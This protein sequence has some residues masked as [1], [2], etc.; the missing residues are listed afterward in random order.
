MISSEMGP[1]VASTRA[2][3][4]TTPSSVSLTARSE[5]SS[6]VPMVACG[7]RERRTFTSVW[8]SARSFSRT[9]S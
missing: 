3:L 5:T 2:P 8:V 4:T 9:C 1:S 7:D 6:S